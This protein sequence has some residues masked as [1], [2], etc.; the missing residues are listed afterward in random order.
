MF[1]WTILE[2][3]AYAAEEKALKSAFARLEYENETLANNF[4]RVCTKAN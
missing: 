2:L 3:L 4:F 1:V